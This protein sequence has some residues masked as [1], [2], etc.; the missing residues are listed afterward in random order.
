VAG[1]QV[2][3]K[4]VAARDPAGFL[5][6][7]QAASLIV[8]P[9][10]ARILDWGVDGQLCY[11][12]IDRVPGVEVASLA[13]GR[14]LDPRSVTDIGEQVAAGLA[15]IHEHGLVH[16]G[17]GLHTL[18]YTG[19]GT[20]KLLDLGVRAASDP[21]AG[22][23]TAASDQYAL[24]ATLYEL[25][26]GYPP[27]AAAAYE[28]SGAGAPGA[29]AGAP[30]G[31][32]VSAQPTIP[33]R[34]LVPDFP[35]ALEGVI[36]R[37]LAPHPGARYP[38]MEEMRREIARTREVT[39]APEL[40]E[41]PPEVHDQPR[42]LWPWMALGIVVLAAIGVGAAY[43][44]GLFSGSG[45][46]TPD[47]V[48]KTLAAAKATLSGAGLTL[49][50]VSYAQ[51]VDDEMTNLAVAKQKPAAGA[52]IAEGG[53]VDV[54]L[55]AGIVEVP[56]VVGLTQAKASAALKE[57][58]LSIA[59]VQTT[60]SA[61]VPKNQVVSQVP[62]AGTEVR[63]GSQ[64][65]LTV[66]AGAETPTV[67]DVTGDT[68]TAATKALN[69]AGFEVKVEHAASD[70]VPAG[71]VIGQQPTAGVKAAEGSTV[72]ITV[73]TGPGASPT[74]TSSPTGSPTP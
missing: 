51:G 13:G 18:V 5:R 16:G 62:E 49:G 28:A 37:A 70:S 30:P 7:V 1:T 34:V 74:P 32:P 42:R 64:V 57:V 55:G 8:H 26:S 44:L 29:P 71:S 19:D 22:L 23:P 14:P 9:N 54:T 20:V 61:D 56:N 43:A 72:T 35:L 38:T 40:F 12:V 6:Q 25:A 59:T 17:I 66:S 2:V 63:A 48:G 47:L 67:P 68:E 41:S 24:G 31:A 3:V 53:K 27:Q 60:P 21:G 39:A 52:S 65:T 50:T 33:L 73:S 36:M 15:A 45:P 69:N 10:I 58:D 4:L 46:T 11:V